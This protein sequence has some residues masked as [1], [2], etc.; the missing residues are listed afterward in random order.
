MLLFYPQYIPMEHE[1]PGKMEYEKN[2]MQPESDSPLQLVRD[3]Q[4][5]RSLINPH[6]I[7]H[8][9]K[10]GRFNLERSNVG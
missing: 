9:N 4:G 7:G 6:T 3:G 1:E 5:V 2:F 10:A 8:G